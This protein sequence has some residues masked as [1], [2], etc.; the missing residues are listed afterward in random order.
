MESLM[1]MGI[2]YHDGESYGLVVHENT[3]FYLP[4]RNKIRAGMERNLLY[5]FDNPIEEE[6]KEEGFPKNLD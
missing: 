1:N 3:M 6:S 4:S 5:T 2:I